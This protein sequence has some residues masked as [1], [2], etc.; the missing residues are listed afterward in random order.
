MFPLAVAVSV[1]K[2]KFASD[3][4]MLSVESVPCVSEPAPVKAVAIVSVPLFVYD[5]DMATLAMAI[6][7]APL[8][9]FDV[10]VKV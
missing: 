7:F 8:N 4:A 3:A 6:S 1:L 10:P 5:P 9:V 2:V